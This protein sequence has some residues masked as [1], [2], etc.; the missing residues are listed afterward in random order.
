M[1][2]HTAAIKT[3]L[4][5][6][7]ENDRSAALDQACVAAKSSATD[8]AELL[9]WLSFDAVAEPAALDLATRKLRHA[10]SLPMMPGAVCRP[11]PKF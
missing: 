4:D 7:F 5:D 1:S 11:T 10:M 2:D 9:R 3:L 6:Y 8:I